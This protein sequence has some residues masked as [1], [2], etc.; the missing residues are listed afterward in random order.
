MRQII[1]ILVLCAILVPI[2]AVQQGLSESE[3]AQPINAA[4]SQVSRSCQNAA[5]WLRAEAR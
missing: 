1:L 5:N 4:I 2:A 3:I